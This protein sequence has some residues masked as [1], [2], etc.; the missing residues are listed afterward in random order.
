LFISM[1]GSNIPGVS[2][3]ENVISQYAKLYITKNV[4]LMFQYCKKIQFYHFKLHMPLD[5]ANMVL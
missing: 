3:A 1:I 2:I 4:I 5:L